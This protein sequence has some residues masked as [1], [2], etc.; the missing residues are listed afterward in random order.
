MVY[1]VQDLQKL[2]SGKRCALESLRN[3]WESFSNDEVR[4]TKATQ[5]NCGYAVPF[6]VTEGENNSVHAH[7]V[8]ATHAHT[9][10][11]KTC[12]QRR[13]TREQTSEEFV[14]HLISAETREHCSLVVLDVLEKLGSNNQLKASYHQ[15]MGNPQ[16]LTN[17]SCGFNSILCKI[18]KKIWV[19]DLS[20][21]PDI[22]KA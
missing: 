4:L 13:E 2:C 21:S 22:V 14:R 10:A 16:H 12:S 5:Y 15:L 6:P 8:W 18:L 19:F 17:I 7:P 20:T 1:H 9:H 3:L 11:P